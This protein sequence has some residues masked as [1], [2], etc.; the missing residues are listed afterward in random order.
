[1]GVATGCASGNPCR[2]PAC[3]SLVFM[4]CVLIQES[5]AK[6]Q[7]RKENREN[8]GALCGFA[9]LREISLCFTQIALAAVAEHG[10]HHGRLAQRRCESPGSKNV[11]SGTRAHQ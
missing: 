10:H 9:A 2:S 7:R 3:T 1:M 4:S 5:P 11:G 6:A 8:R